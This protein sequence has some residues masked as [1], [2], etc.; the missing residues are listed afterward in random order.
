MTLPSDSKVIGSHTRAYGIGQ[1]VPAGQL[2]G[3]PARR[4]TESYTV[5]ILALMTVH[6]L[7]ALAMSAAWW[8]TTLHAL[9]TLAAGVYFLAR[10]TTPHRLILVTAYITG[11]ELLW[12]GNDAR[13]FWETGKYA[14]SV[15]LIL[16]LIKEQKIGQMAR[17]PLVYFILLLPSLFLLPAFDREAIAFNLSGPFALAV[18]TCYFSTVRLTREQVTQL[19][20][21]ML[22]PIVGL[23]FLAAYEIVTAASLDFIVG[24]KATAA[25]IGP[26]QVS[27]M[28]G[29][30]FV[31]AFL[32]FLLFKQQYRFVRLVMLIIF[33]W[34]VAQ[35]AL[36]FSRGG[37]WTGLIAVV[38]IGL[39]WLRE[40]KALVT[41][42]L[43]SLLS[44]AILQFLLLPA[45]DTFTQGTLSARLEDSR[46]TGRDHIIL[47]DW[48]TFQEHPWFGV[49]P[50]QS[51]FYHAQTFRAASAHTEYTRLLAEHG[52]LGA[53]SLLLFLIFAVLRITRSRSSPADKALAVG[54]TAW[55][56]L[57]MVHA[58][59]RLVAP[60]FIFGLAAASFALHNAPETA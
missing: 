22:L 42:L 27:S 6:M 49:G 58:A 20:L 15:L 12:R 39:F 23:G 37:L 1:Q 8:I 55:C 44:L 2:P 36:T 34:L 52:S 57:F 26:N 43:S 56:L 9:V 3:N 11:A 32:C 29:L 17:W 5:Q 41:L 16:S 59:L 31:T 48:L 25:G 51:Y 28:L 10:D 13:I 19:L 30:G 54:L 24:S 35:T 33:I 21:A 7:L 46:L 50:G 60:S 4:L 47:A 14:V 40:P 38:I 18:A 53:A 45:L